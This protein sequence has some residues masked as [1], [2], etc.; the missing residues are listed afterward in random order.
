ME[1]NEAL[2]H[3]DAKLRE[4]ALAG[5]DRARKAFI[6]F[7]RRWYRPLLRFAWTYRGLPREEAEDEVAETLIAAFRLMDRYDPRRP[8]SPWLYRVA[9]NRFANAVRRERRR[10]EAE[11]SAWAPEEDP[12]E[13][14]IRADEGTRCAAAVR[15]LPE[16][17][18]RIALLKF[19]ENLNSGQIG[20]ALGMN[21]AT[22]RWRLAAIRRE[23]ERRMNQPRKEVCP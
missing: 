5:G 8:L 22:V 23:I 14:A 3:S 10:A 12:E 21:P 18:R 2:P 4:D 6:L 19:A 11:R 15:A 13:I 16:T 20:R 7:W 17:D 9:A 1:E